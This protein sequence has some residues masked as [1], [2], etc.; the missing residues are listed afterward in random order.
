MHCQIAFAATN[1]DIRHGGNQAYYAADADYVQMPP[2]ETFE[3]PEAY[4][5]ALGHEVCHWTRQAAVPKE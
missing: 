4:C 5:S 1:G 2:F 3:F